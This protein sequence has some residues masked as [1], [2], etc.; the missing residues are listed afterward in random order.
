MADGATTYLSEAIDHNVTGVSGTN[1]SGGGLPT[2]KIAAAKDP[3]RGLL[4]KLSHRSDGNAAS[5][6]D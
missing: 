2:A 1:W 6:S 4:Q 3:A 5:L